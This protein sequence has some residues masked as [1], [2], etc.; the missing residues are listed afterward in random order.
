MSAALS[1]EVLVA[2][3]LRG[4]RPPGGTTTVPARAEG[5]TNGCM[6]LA[7]VCGYGVPY[8]LTPNT[9]DCADDPPEFHRRWDAFAERFQLRWW[10]S[11]RLAPIG[12]RRWIAL[13]DGLIAPGALHAVAMAGDELHRDPNA[14]YGDPAY[15]SIKPRQIRGA[16]AL[17]P[18]DAPN[19]TVAC[20]PI[21]RKEPDHA[22]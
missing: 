14:L 19:P 9:D 17:L 15:E 6:N 22:L 11:D 2:A 8:E 7:V 3:R 1:E 21:T 13:V 18:A 4:S 20:W 5:V 12:L 10:R 16:M